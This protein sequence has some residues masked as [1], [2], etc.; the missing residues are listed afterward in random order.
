MYGLEAVILDGTTLTGCK[1]FS[2]S[3]R[4][5]H[6]SLGADGTLHQTFHSVARKAPKVDF[7]T[8]AVKS[9]L[10]ALTTS[11]D[12]PMKNIAT[13]VDFNFSRQDDTK[14]G[15]NA[16]GHTGSRF[17]LG[18]VYCNAFRWSPGGDGLE[19][20]CELFGLSANGTTDPIT[21]I[22][23]TLVSPTS[24]EVFTLTSATVGGQ[25]ITKVNS[26]EIAIAHQGENNDETLCYNVGLPMPTQMR[27]AG[28]SGP[29]E[30]SGTIEILDQVVAPTTSGTVVLV[31]TQMAF[32]GTLGAAT[33]TL[34]INAAMIREDSKSA[35]Q[36]SPGTRRLMFKGRHDGTNRPLSWATT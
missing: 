14:P 7:S 34:T 5:R 17:T 4:E 33:V 15:K 31:F 29:I 19:A 12:V 23:P 13:A 28:A 6:V 30:I 26:V 9:L 24:A 22:T 10:G 25:A 21:G 35:Q 20:S 1:G 2:L 27:V 16:T 11:L 32:G 3:Q 18:H 8:V 36:G